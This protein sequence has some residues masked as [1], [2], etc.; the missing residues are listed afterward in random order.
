MFKK[1][2]L[3]KS[4][5]VKS[6]VKVKHSLTHCLTE[7][8]AELAALEDLRLS[9]AMGYISI[10]PSTV[11][12]SFNQTCQRA[13]L[14]SLLMNLFERTQNKSFNITTRG[15]CIRKNKTMTNAWRESSSKIKNI[16]LIYSPSG[17]PRSMWCF[18]FF[19]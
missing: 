11:G 9:R 1:F 4:W 2:S 16:L 8:E 6:V 7:A 13:N 19:L 17:H 14:R 15:S 3:F 18:S 5:K 12:E 10:S